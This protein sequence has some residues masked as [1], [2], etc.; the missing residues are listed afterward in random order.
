MPP[1]AADPSPRIFSHAAKSSVPGN[2]VSITNCAN[3]MPARSATESVA[4]N[5]VGAVARQ[6]EDERAEHVHAVL[7]ERLQ[8]RRRARRR[9]VEVLVDVLEPFGRDRLDADERA[10]DVRAPH[11]VEELGILRRFHRDLR[12]EHGVARQLRQR[13]PSAR[14][15]RRG[16]A[17]SCSS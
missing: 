6:A 5:V 11:R 4:S 9:V 2:G 12:E 1:T 7:A 13:R 15:A 3:V 16:V 14:S 8:P 17:F 10:L